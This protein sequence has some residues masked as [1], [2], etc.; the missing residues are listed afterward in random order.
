MS[1]FAKYGNVK[2]NATDARHKDW[3]EV[4]SFD[5]GLERSVNTPT[6]SVANRV[7]SETMVWDVVLSKTLDEASA[8]LLM[9]AFT[10]KS[11]ADLTVHQLSTAVQGLNVV[12]YVFSNAL[13]TK[14]VTTS[15]GDRPLETISFNFTK[16]AFNF[17]IVDE[18]GKTR[19]V[20][21]EYDLATARMAGM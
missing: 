7:A 9:E 19:P 17:T 3:M 11:Q 13:I 12:E 10:R 14:Y 16:I 4:L 18:A 20:T 21:G 15:T 1:I 5:W 2:G 6:G 8:S